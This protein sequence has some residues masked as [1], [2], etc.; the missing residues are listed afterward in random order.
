MFRDM[1]EQVIAQLVFLLTGWLETTRDL[2]ANIM[3]L[4][5]E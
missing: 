4:F 2:W 3:A 5:A 1:L